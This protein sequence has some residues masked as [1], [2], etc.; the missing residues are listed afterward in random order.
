M[1]PFQ[2]QIRGRTSSIY[3]RST[4]TA[5]D[6]IPMTTIST[7]LQIKPSLPEINLLD[8]QISMARGSTMALETT[9]PRL[10]MQNTTPNVD[11]GV[12][13]RTNATT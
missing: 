9:R 10:R 5:K 8:H 1:N 4:D 11:F 12:K 7:T 3:S 13:G 6:A 2:K